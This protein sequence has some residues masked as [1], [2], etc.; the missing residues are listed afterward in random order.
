MLTFHTQTVETLV[1][2]THTKVEQSLSLAELQKPM[3]GARRFKATNCAS[4]W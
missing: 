4:H 2:V 1:T 3:Q